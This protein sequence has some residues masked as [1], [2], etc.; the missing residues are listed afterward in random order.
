MVDDI[1]DSSS[2]RRN[3]PCVHHLFGTDIAI[4]SGN[5][6]Y[7]APM[8]S[9]A[10]SRKYSDEVLL[11]LNI[12]YLEEMV[13]LHIGQGWDILWHNI[14]KLG[15]EYPSE[16]QYLQMTAHKTGVLARLSSRMVCAALKAD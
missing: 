4:N 11:K 15:A 3:K 13:Q 10:K 16:A 12:I 7:Y 1:E 6:M 8:L 2:I 14:D 9:L 5:M